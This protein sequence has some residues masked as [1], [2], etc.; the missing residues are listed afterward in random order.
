MASSVAVASI[1]LSTPSFVGTSAIAVVLW[2]VEANSPSVTTFLF[3]DLNVRDGSWSNVF[4]VTYW[5]ACSCIRPKSWQEHIRA[6]V[7]LL[8]L[9]SFL[10][11]SNYRV[12][13]I[14]SPPLMCTPRFLCNM[15]GKKEFL[16]PTLVYGFFSFH[17]FH[18][19]EHPF[20]INCI[21]RGLVVPNFFRLLQ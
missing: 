17:I 9:A 8:D 5:C 19:I 3:P 12:L 13:P 2:A 18:A 21:E 6:P 16:T 1:I 20:N 10:N 7:I 15:Y 11:T 4:R 14:K